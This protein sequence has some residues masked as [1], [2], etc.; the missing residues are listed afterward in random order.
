[1]LNCSIR[2]TGVKIFIMIYTNNSKIYLNAFIYFIKKWGFFKLY[3]SLERKYY[4]T[5]CMWAEK[6][7][8]KKIMILG[9]M[10]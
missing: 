10:K 6:E 8:K 9:K 4:E 5:I 2:I 7:I 1:M 3:K